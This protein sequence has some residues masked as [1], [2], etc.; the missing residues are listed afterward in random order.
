METGISVTEG[1]AG[2]SQSVATTTDKEWKQGYQS[3]SGEQGAVRVLLL[4]LL[5]QSGYMNISYR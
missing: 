1:G 2:G 3:Q 5:I 4:L